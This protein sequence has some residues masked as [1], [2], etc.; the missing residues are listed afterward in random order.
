MKEPIKYYLNLSLK[1][2]RGEK[3]KDLIGFE[4]IY[5]CSSK[6]RIKSLARL[7][8]KK[9]PH[10]E[11]I[12]KPFVTKKG[13]IRVCLSKNGTQVKYQVHRLIALT[14][15]PNPQNKPH[16]NHLKGFKYD[17]REGQIDWATRSEDELHSFRV[18]GKKA[19]SPWTGKSGE[20]F[21]TNKGVIQISLCG[22]MVG[23]YCSRSEAYRQ[24]GICQ[25]CIGECVKG[26]RKTAGGYI[27]K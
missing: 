18:L 15:K 1:N 4:G 7:D 19:N 20:G 23:V 5:M 16:V 9:V 24:T 8:S 3:W 17:N 26:S 2:I 21:P 13:Y 12:L 6:G 10:K 27:W 14:F 25:T 11:I 22:H